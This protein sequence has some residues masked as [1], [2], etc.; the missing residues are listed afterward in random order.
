MGRG[1]PWASL[2]PVAIAVEVR[3]MATR[4]LLVVVQAVAGSG[5]VAHP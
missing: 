3:H 2:Q 1:E 4:D 5:P